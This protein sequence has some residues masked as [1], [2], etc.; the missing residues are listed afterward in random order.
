MCANIL[1]NANKIERVEVWFDNENKKGTLD[2]LTGRQSH[3]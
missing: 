2:K 1:K 3:I